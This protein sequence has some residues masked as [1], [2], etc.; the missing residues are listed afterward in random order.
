LE[1]RIGGKCGP[2]SGDPVDLKVTVRQIK[3]SHSQIA[4]DEA[5]VPMGEAVWLEADNNMHL[6]INS[7]RSQTYSPEAFT[8]LGLDITALDLVVVKSTQ[9]FHAKFAPLSSAIFYVSTPGAMR[10]DFENIPYSQCE[11]DYWP[12]VF[13]PLNGDS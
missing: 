4:Y 11:V 8:G 10:S 7:T 2:V 6:V 9:H 3:S 12:K 1:L 5:T 13:D